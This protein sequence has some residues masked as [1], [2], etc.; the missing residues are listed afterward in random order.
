L[1][2][3]LQKSKNGSKSDSDKEALTGTNQGL[4]NNQPYVTL[5][6]YAARF[7]ANWGVPIAKAA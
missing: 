7:D 4:S 3:I 1:K 5:L 2:R 6:N